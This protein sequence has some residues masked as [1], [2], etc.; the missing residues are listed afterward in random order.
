MKLK[1]KK[2]KIDGTQQLQQLQQEHHHQQIK[3]KEN[4]NEKYEKNSFKIFTFT[5]QQ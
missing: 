5:K 1:I 3:S 4:I 2:K